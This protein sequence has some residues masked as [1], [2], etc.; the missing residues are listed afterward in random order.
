MENR[1]FISLKY[2]PVLSQTLSIM[3]MK[4][5]FLEILN[6]ELSSHKHKTVL[7]SYASDLIDFYESNQISTEAKFRQ[8]FDKY[9]GVSP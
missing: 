3:N 1:K 6:Q 2:A 4:K 8:L 9:I 7:I 5:D